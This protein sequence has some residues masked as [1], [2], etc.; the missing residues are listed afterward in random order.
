ML[1]PGRPLHERREGH[2][3]GARDLR[4]AAAVGRK[5]MT[6]VPLSLYFNDRGMAKVQLGLGKGK[7]HIDRRDDIKKREW[8]REQARVM[9]A[10]G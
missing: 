7:T 4:L 6:L 5:G 10:R 1:V 3:L 2:D 9:R 8:Q